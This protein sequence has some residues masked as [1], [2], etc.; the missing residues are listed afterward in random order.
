QEG[1]VRHAS[2]ERPPEPPAVALGDGGQAEEAQRRNRQG[3]GDPVGDDEVLEVDQR[4]GQQGGRED[5]IG[6][7]LPRGSEPGG[8]GGEENSVARLHQGVPDGDGIP[9]VPAL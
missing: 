2:Q 9:A 7:Q 4:D 3:G 5:E 6:G 1:E 8:Y